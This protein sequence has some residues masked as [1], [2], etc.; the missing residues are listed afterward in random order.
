MT[1]E[2]LINSLTH[3]RGTHY[4][5]KHVDGSVGDSESSASDGGGQRRAVIL[6]DR[7][8][9]VDLRLGIQML[10]KIVSLG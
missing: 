5:V 7:Y 10:K 6:E 3:Q 8:E 9:N 1:P 2:D 4:D